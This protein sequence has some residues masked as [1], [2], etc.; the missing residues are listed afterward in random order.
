MQ[1]YL[2]VKRG[3]QSTLALPLLFLSWLVIRRVRGGC[4]GVMHAG[5]WF[6]CPS[7]GAVGEIEDILT[8]LYFLLF[9]CWLLPLKFKKICHNHRC[10]AFSGPLWWRCC[11]ERRFGDLGITRKTWKRELGYFSLWRCLWDS[12]RYHPCQSL[13]WKGLCF[14]IKNDVS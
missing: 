8:G 14:T 13:W 6:G 11:W 9:C 4:R 1:T 10:F 2:C 3:F 5:L 7:E 12:L